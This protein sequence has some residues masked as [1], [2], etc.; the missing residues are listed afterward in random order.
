MQATHLR[1]LTIFWYYKKT[2][3]REIQFAVRTGI[4]TFTIYWWNTSLLLNQLSM[5]YLTA[6]NDKICCCCWFKF[7]INYGGY[8]LH[9]L[10]TPC[11]ICKLLFGLSFVHMLCL[12]FF[13]HLKE[14]KLMYGMLY[15]IK[16]FVNRIS[17]A[18]SYPLVYNH[19]T[20]GLGE[21][22]F[23]IRIFC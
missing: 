4:Q 14:F 19:T 6:P 12:E 16:S 2:P 20:Y 5:K 18:D 23:L 10:T 1:H 13:V 11:I 9:S 22:C 17:P 8:N 7:T 21:H 3:V 15:S